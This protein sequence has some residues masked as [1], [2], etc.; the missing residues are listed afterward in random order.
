MLASKNLNINEKDGVV[1]IT[2]PLFDKTNLV[3]HAFTTRIGGVSEGYYASMNMSFTNGDSERK[4]FEN[5]RR[6]CAVIGTDPE[7]AVLSQQTHTNNVR[8]VTENDIG[9]GIVK[10][11]DYTDVDGLITNISGVTLVTQYADC[12]PLLFCDKVKKVIATSHAGWR[13]TASE[14][15]RVTIEKMRDN[16]DC[17]PKDI[18]C[19]IGPSICQGCYEVDDAV[20]E[21]LSK[22]PYLNKDKIF[23][24]KDNGK[25]QLDL[26]ETN[27][28]ILMNA[29]IREGNIDVTDLCTNCHPDVFHSHRFTKGK[30]GNLAA[31]IALK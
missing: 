6:I 30:R 28:E 24:K 10:G 8:I 13:G 4:V 14:I 2:F 22:I 25:Y 17:D 18:I 1:Y 29:G 26:W 23:I 20:F 19:A 15:G 16:F 11:R 7:R 12:T 5:Y 31:L 9:K 21:P 3:N 27:K